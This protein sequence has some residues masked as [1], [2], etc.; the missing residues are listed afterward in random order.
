ME[1]RGIR[2]YKV[3]AECKSDNRFTNVS[4]SMNIT[5]I[6]KT[7]D[8]EMRITFEHTTEYKPD[9]ARLRFEGLVLV[10]GKKN[11]LDGII[12]RWEKEKMLPKDMFEMLMNVIKY[13]AEANG[14]LVAKALNMAPPLLEPKVQ[15]TPRP[16]K[17]K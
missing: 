15:V 9:I 7:K 14:V 1:W 8:D 6:D 16:A 13:N 10:G 2:F 4:V 12:S 3:D 11:D 5:G 17:K